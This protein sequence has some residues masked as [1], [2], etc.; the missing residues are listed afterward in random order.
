MQIYEL[1]NAKA[2]NS[3]SNIGE[4]PAEIQVAETDPNL[5]QQQQQ[6]V[7]SQHQSCQTDDVLFA[8]GGKINILH[9]ALSYCIS[10]F[11]TDIW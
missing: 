10:E 1:E 5:E 11:N 3:R 2:N 8:V 6:P 4:Q 7:C 9:S